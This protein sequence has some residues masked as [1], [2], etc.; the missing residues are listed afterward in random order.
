MNAV[1]AEVL[2]D[3]G[4]LAALGP[5]WRGL[6]RRV[7][8]ALPFLSPEWLL[9][10]WRHFAPGRL[11]TLAARQEGR[12]VAL[13]PCY[14]E[15]GALGRRI[16][17]I[18]ISLSDHLDILADPACEADALQALLAAALARRH[19]WDVWELENLLPD[20]VALRLKL[21]VECS[22]EVAAQTTCPYL[23]VPD[24]AL[25]LEPLLTQKKRRALNL[26]RNRAARSG[27]LRVERARGPA[28]PDALQ[29]LFR[30]HASRWRS[31]HE[32][33]VLASE[34][35]RG[36]QQDAAPE[37][38]RAGLLRLYVVSLRGVAA[39]AY[40][41]LT[42]ASRHYAYLTGFD[43]D[44]DF[45]SPGALVMAHAFGE[46]IAEGCR[47]IDFLRGGETYKYAWG[48]VDRWN[49][50]RSIRHGAAHG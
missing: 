34:Q 29:H 50:K 43:P 5:E 15:D 6:W 37:L 48:A 4:A 44:F 26:A 36:F 33:G 18:G 41:G 12:L 9:P 47:E 24:G 49:V 42:H 1:S 27:D 22:N 31:R 40:Y 16:L 14:I 23:P 39:A 8:D 28:I 30:L 19:E 32:P 35:V 25:T 13:A 2:E 11:F 7:P 20:A 10:W 17:P 21:A 45:E 46:A 3:A 38:D